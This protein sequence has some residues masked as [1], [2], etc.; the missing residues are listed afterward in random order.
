MKTCTTCHKEKPLSDFYKQADRK[1]G[2]SSCKS[3]FNRYCVDRWIQKKKDAI[4]YKGGK[5]NRCGYDDHYAAL[6]FHHMDPTT[7]DVMWNKL[8]LRS[9]DKIVVELDKC[10]LL[11]AN[12]HSI[13]HALSS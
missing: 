6:Q 7:K 10:D 1:K 5:C 12:C 11:C 2:A 13:E 9:W 4:N 3:C 8:R